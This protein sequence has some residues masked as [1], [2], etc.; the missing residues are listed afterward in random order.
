MV[1]MNAMTS[2]EVSAESGWLSRNVALA[3]AAIAPLV[4]GAVLSLVRG[5][6]ANTSAALILVLVVVGVACLGYRS[7]GLVAAASAGVWFDFFLT[8]PHFRFVIH[9][10]GDIET[11]V[12]LLLIGAAVTEVVQW[13]QRK[14]TQLRDRDTYLA[15]L[16]ATSS[17]DGRDDHIF[18]Q[19]VSHHLIALL[20]LDRCW[21]EN[22]VDLQAPRLDPDGQVRHQGRVLLVD[23]EGLP[24][25]SAIVLPVHP[26][27][28]SSPGFVLTAS[29]HVARPTLQQRRLAAALAAQAGWAL[30][31]ESP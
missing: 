17:H 5:L 13:G 19:T 28:A 7:A 3:I 31:E 10:A 21:W 14:Q 30:A 9:D 27:A 25:D 23:E 29:A 12:V 16:L 4:V 11:M 18:V 20:D 15:A 24:T 6:V 1:N 26:H 22:S 8:A 2:A